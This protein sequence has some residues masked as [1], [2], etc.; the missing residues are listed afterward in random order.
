LVC[1]LLSGVLA[2]AN[3]HG[4]ADPTTG[5][6]LATVGGGGRYDD[7][8]GI[9]APQMGKVPA[10]GIG[11]GFERLFALLMEKVFAIPCCPE[12]FD[13]PMTRADG[14]TFAI[15]RIS[16]QEQKKQPDADVLV[17]YVVGKNETPEQSQRLRSYTMRCAAALWKAGIKVR[18]C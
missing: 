5:R 12:S 15:P 13:C 4:D 7:L 3:A 9:F 11:I 10:V 14:I 17:G 18:I 16:T 1:V 2:D 6:P 8:V